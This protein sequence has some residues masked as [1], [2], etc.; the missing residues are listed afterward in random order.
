[1]QAT[2]YPG[3]L[4]AAV[5]ADP[6]FW[7]GEASYAKFRDDGAFADLKEA[8]GRLRML[9]PVEGGNVSYG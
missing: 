2:F 9:R 3:D 6:E 8:R 5:R 1:V 7:N 4:L